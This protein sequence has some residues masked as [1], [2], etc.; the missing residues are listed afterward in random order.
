M[1]ILCLIY[2]NYLTYLTYQ[3]YLISPHTY[4]ISPSVLLVD[5][6]RYGLHTTFKY[7]RYHKCPSYEADLI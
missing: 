5:H 2:L 4:L 7:Y 6:T 1:L 3:T